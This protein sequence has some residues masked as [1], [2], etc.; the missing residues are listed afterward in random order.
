MFVGWALEFLSGSPNHWG[1]KMNKIVMWIFS[2]TKVGQLLDGK[3][4]V[5]GAGMILLS[6]LIQAAEQIA[7][8]FPGVPWISQAA[9][10]MGHILKAVEPYLNDLGLGLISVG[11]VHKRAKA[12]A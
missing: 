10:Q 6:A 7:P 1:R 9:E 5:I 3:K 11:L 4:T 8:L 12:R 2:K